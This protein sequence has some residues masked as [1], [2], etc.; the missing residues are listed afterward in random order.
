MAQL[1][2]KS[3]RKL[4]DCGIIKFNGRFVDD[5]LVVVKSI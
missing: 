5:I 1:E 3:I 2:E 4:A